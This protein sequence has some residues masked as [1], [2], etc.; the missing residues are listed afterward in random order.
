M[1]TPWIGVL[2]RY[3]VFSFYP[4][5]VPKS[6][7]F[8]MSTEVSTQ[9][10]VKSN[11][12]ATG[13]AMFSMF[14]G[15]GNVVFPLALGVYAQDQNIFAIIGLLLT[16]V[17]VPFIGLM[18][19]TLFDGQ[20]EAFFKR[21][22]NVPGMTLA[23][24]IMGLI[25]PFGAMPRVVTVAF[26]SVKSFLPAG[27]E[28]WM[29]SAFACT[30]I[31]FLTFRKSRIIEV[32][33][34]YLTPILLAS[35]GMI[36]VL[37]LWSAPEAAQTDITAFSAFLSGL[38]EGYK[39][40]D[41]MGAFFFSSVVLEVLEQGIAP[42]DKSNH[43]K[44][45]VKTLKAGC[46][47]MTLLAAVYVGGSFVTAAYASELGQFDRSEVLAATAFKVL[48]PNAGII[49]AIAVSMACLTT[50]IA[51]AAVFAE[52]LH[53]DV[54]FDK[55]NYKVCLVLTMFA[56]FLISTLNFMGIAAILEPIL[57]VCYPALIMLCIL[58]LAYKLF[59]FEPVKGPFYGVF[60]FSVGLFFYE[61]LV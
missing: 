7:V 59:G 1:A 9:E 32:L 21:I 51:L 42:D 37:G 10:G 47:G 12:V 56:T 61:L 44:M 41:M 29:F 28:V 54:F 40:M 14:F 30:L 20:Y 19:M 5:E 57:I 2:I 13:F 6:R 11:T 36:I 22:G 8:I 48:G 17:G 45:I 15:A 26:G 60:L 25:G 3:E 16:A 33:G 39:T 23:F 50:A 58:N 35:L 46:I 31:Y 34:Y 4:Q 49:A 55:I 52:F 43:K 27:T 24:F 18:S 53:R 38:T